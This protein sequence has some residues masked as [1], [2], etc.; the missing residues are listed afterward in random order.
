MA[1]VATKHLGGGNTQRHICLYAID[2]KQARRAAANWQYVECRQPMPLAKTTLSRCETEVRSRCNANSVFRNFSAF[3]YIF[4][5]HSKIAIRSANF[6]TIIT[7]YLILYFEKNISLLRKKTIHEYLK[8][9]ITDRLLFPFFL[10]VIFATTIF[11]GEINGK[12]DIRNKKNWLFY[13]R[14]YSLKRNLCPLP[15]PLSS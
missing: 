6:K 13:E 5:L 8:C 3:S 12:T 7:T 11:N 9:S 15:A 1:T 10:K 2:F 4:H 14:I